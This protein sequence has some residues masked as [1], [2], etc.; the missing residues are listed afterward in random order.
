MMGELE[1]GDAW[2]DTVHSLLRAA[3]REDVGEGDWTTLWTVGSDRVATAEIVAKERLVVAG[4]EVARMAFQ[5]V[6]PALQVEL[7]IPD[8]EVAEAGEAVLRVEGGARG[9]LTAERTALNFLGRLSGVATLTRQF[10]ER[11]SGTG[12]RIT[13]TRKT[14]PGWRTLE[15]RAVRVGGG[16]NHRMGLYDMVLVKENHI[17]AAAG[18]REAVRGVREGNLRGLPVEVEVRRPEEVEELREAGVDRILLD[19]MSDEA[20]REALRRVREWPLPHPELEASGNMTLERVRGVA[21][22]GVDWISVGALT[23]SV[24]TVDLSLRLRLS[25][26]GEGR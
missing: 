12:A 24:R 20:L 23:H 7:R 8:G 1:A 17:C 13:D 21:E 4:G 11:V 26:R 6:D 25:S 3:L 5:A 16:T 19:N 22:A 10:V 18:I 2:G 15:K 9:I 14:T